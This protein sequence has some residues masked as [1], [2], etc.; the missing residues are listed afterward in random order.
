VPVGDY[1]HYVSFVRRKRGQVLLVHN[2]RLPGSVRVR[3]REIRLFD[4]IRVV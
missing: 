2:E 1:G 4:E 3:Q